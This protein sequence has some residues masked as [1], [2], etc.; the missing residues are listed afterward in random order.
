MAARVSAA[1]AIALSGL[2]AP[3]PP[4]SPAPIASP[5]ASPLPAAA[6]YVLVD[7]GTGNVLAGYNERL[8]LPPA[9]L[10]KVLT[11]L[12][13]V[14]YL[15]ATATVT[16]TAASELVYPDRVGME[17]GRPWPLRETLQALLVMSAND[18][19][20]ALAQRVSGSLQAFGALMQRSARQI[21][22]ADSPIF[23]DPAGLDG[24]EGV[25]GG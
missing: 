12:I 13:A 16:A 20:Y 14:A 15:P 23:H 1:C 18:S 5:A 10:T 22:M 3:S 2:I 8:P 25:G 19:A 24:T 7:V 4:T 21:G 6:S 9:S 11:A 17:V